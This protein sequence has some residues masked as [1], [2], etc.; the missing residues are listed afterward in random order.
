M[1]ETALSGSTTFAGGK[2]NRYWLYVLPLLGLLVAFFVVPILQ[3]LWISITDPEPGLQNYRI[4]LSSAAVQRILWT[5]L[6]ICLITTL[7]ALIGGYIIAYVMVHVGRR[8]LVWMMLFVLVPF[9]MSVLVR[10][11]AW[12]TLLRD[13]GLINSA[14]MDTGLIADPIAMVRNEFGVIVG[15]VH[16][17]LPYAVLPLYA[18][19]RGIDPRLMLAARGLGAGEFETFWRVFLPLS[20]PG[21]A[22][23]GLLIFIFSLGFFVTPAL[24]G[25]G[26]TV[27]IAEYV[28]VQIQQTVRWGLGTML[29]SVLL[30]AVFVLVATLSRFLKLRDLFGAK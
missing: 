26:K 9:W 1:S 4:L 28:S 21:I 22:A 11:F 24:L 16:F 29:A 8:H 25:G 23:A 20:L 5:T 10:A 14:L 30:M 7:I 6:R 2:V 13:N 12:I 3:V 19:M 17:M 18:N 27:M 15:M